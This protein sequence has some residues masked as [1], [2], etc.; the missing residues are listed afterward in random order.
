MRFNF[1]E[2]ISACL[3]EE[4]RP[5]LTLLILL[6]RSHQLVRVDSFTITLSSELGLLS[7]LSAHQ[8]LDRLAEIEP[9]IERFEAQVEHRALDDVFLH[10]MFIRT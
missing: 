10:F 4:P 6:S 5:P 9:V 8:F 7:G 1:S 2:F 3:S